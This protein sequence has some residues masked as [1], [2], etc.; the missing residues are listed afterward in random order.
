[1]TT[2]ETQI[3]AVTLYPDRAR[4]LRT[5]QLQVEPGSYRLEVEDLPQQ[6]DAASVRAAARG[7]ARARLLGVDVRR[8]YYEQTP[9]TAIREL[10]AQIEALQDELAVLDARATRLKE[11]RGAAQGLAGQAEIY[12]RGLARGRLTPEAQM[13]LFDAVQAR[14]EAI[15]AALQEIALQ[16]RD[17]NRR[18][19]KLQKEV[20]RAQGQRATERNVAAVDIEV[21]VAGE[22]TV[23]LLYMVAQAGW[24]PL[25]DLRLLEEER[26]TLSVGYLAEARQRTGED[27]R[28]VAL[29]LSTARPALAET[30]PELDPWYL[31]L[32]QPPPPREALKRAARPMALRAAMDTAGAEMDDFL[33]QDERAE[34]PPEMEAEPVVA[35]VASEGAA[36]TYRVPGTVTVP[37]DG[38]PRKVTVA[39]FNLDPALDYVTA[40]KLVEA[41]YR[42]ATV[43]NASP[44]T[45]L[46]GKANLFAGETFIGVTALELTA[47]DGKIELYL[48][49][50]DRIKV[51]REL[52]QRDVDKVLLR[53]RRRLR[54]AYQIKLE[55]LLMSETRVLLHDQIPTAR[56]ESIKVKLE[57]ATLPPTEQSKLGLLKWELTLAPGEKREIGFEFS[58]E[59]PKDIQ[60]T[61]L[62]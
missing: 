58:V 36:V 26:A 35:L 40:P 49:V 1:M 4:V 51:K 57:A 38:E 16:R 28:E 22:L 29:T 55:N 27:W 50:D 23:E 7:T 39:Q 45:L 10:E 62:I 12:A 54:Y 18:L 24:T 61:G 21:T 48:G 13:A 34:A 32:Y 25:Y 14:A 47:P 44:Y 6:L 43:T 20:Q 46:P 56:H 30:A 52:Q 19:A 33:I 15:D 3:T 42:R 11:D 8:K 41:A 31:N 17:L 2:L 5:G 37:A 59:H 53:D 60:V 9:V